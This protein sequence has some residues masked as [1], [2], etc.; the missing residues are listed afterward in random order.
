[1]SKKKYSTLSTEP[2]TKEEERRMLSD[3]NLTNKEKTDLL[4]QHN[5]R[6]VTSI[7]KKYTAIAEMDDMI[8]EGII[9]LYRA[10]KSFDF[11]KDIK[12][13]T[14]AY[15]YVVKAIQEY[16]SSENKSH[17]I[18]RNKS[19]LSFN[20][21]PDDSGESDSM[22]SKLENE[23]TNSS[24][25]QPSGVYND[26]F[27]HEQNVLVDQLDSLLLNS[28]ILDHR[29]IHVLRNRYLTNKPLTLMQ[30]GKQIGI[31]HSMVKIIGDRAIQKIRSHL[32]NKGISKEDFFISV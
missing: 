12:F 4:V 17:S 30:I 16:L 28:D 29:E 32:E 5:K 13:C 31:S 19:M 25:Q 10:A 11:S 6:L 2:L 22:T 20:Y 21:S 3:S 14:Y 9:G 8:Q 24:Y 1:M 26:V 18:I 7:A 23:V 27:K 15:W